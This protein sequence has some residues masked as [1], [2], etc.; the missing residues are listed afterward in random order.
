MTTPVPRYH[1]HGTGPRVDDRAS[2]P[3][4]TVSTVAA[5]VGIRIR[6]RS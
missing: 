1:V 6:G 4:L 5:L 3:A 2:L